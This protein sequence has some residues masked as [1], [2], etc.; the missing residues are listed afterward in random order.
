MDGS[1]FVVEAALPPDSRYINGQPQYQEGD[2][3]GN[4]FIHSFDQLIN[5]INQ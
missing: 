3:I 4:S 1:T 5:S 2:D